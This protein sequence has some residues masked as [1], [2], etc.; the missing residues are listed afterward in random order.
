[1]THTIQSRILV[2]LNGADEDN[3][4]LLLSVYDSLHDLNDLLSKLDYTIQKNNIELNN[5][6]KNM[7]DLE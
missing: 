5:L 4:N 6:K 2:T 1:M 3:I 7:E